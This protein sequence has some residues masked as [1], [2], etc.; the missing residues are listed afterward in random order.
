MAALHQISP[1]IKVFMRLR[2][3]L[4]L[5]LATGFGSG[6]F[7]LMPGTAGSLAAVLLYYFLPLGDQ[8]WSLVI[9][10]TI[11]TGVWTGTFAEREYGKDPG[12]VVIDEF[13]G[14]WLSLV[15]LPAD[16]LTVSGGFVLF[17]IFDIIKPFPANRAQKI[18][19]GSGIM[20]D[21][22]IAAVYTQA[23]LRLILYLLG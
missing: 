4:I 7:P 23:A 13:A 1:L 8:I 10:L 2:R 9:L 11:I 12:V 14:Q 17:R 6:Y 5:A 19:G 15:F 3:I 22:L 18:K 21:D 20:L 16:L